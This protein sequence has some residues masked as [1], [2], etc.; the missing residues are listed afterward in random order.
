MEFTETHV[1]MSKEMYLHFQDC[2]KR[3]LAALKRAYKEQ[4]RLRSQQDLLI[5]RLY[6]P[7]S[8]GNKQLFKEIL[9]NA[10]LEN[11][12]RFDTQLYRGKT[13][14]QL[15]EEIEKAIRNLD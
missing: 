10:F 15:Q 13:K 5:M 8:A 3:F 2:E 4:E 6:Y 11:S 12:I 1:T 7:L 14:D 9:F